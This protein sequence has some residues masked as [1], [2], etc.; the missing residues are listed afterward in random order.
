MLERDPRRNERFYKGLSAFGAPRYRK[1]LFSDECKR[2]VIN[3]HSVSKSVLR[4]MA[5]NGHVKSP[6]MRFPKDDAGIAMP[7]IQMVSEGI[8]NASTGTF[9]CQYHDAHFIDAIDRTPIQADDP[10]VQDLLLYRAVL[11]ELWLLLAT[12][13]KHSEMERDAPH[14][15]NFVPPWGHQS[16]RIESLLYLRRCLGESLGFDRSIVATT[17]VRHM[18]RKVRTDYPILACSYAFGGTAVNIEVDFAKGEVTP[19]GVPARRGGVEPHICWGFTVIPETGEHT[20]LMSWLEGSMSEDYFAHFRNLSGKELEAAV[21]AEL[22][23]FCERW[24]L[25]PK[26]WEAYN[27]E[28]QRAILIAYDNIQELMTGKFRWSDRGKQLWYEYMGVPNRHQLNLFR[29][30]PNVFKNRP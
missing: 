21:S 16:M 24:F 8:N 13:P 18:V 4:S 28:K 19:T 14:I 2:E 11:R 9:A 22:I 26:V 30:N 20:V 7:D 1:C 10:Y 27:E 23:V 15:T 3:A 29:Y 12:N 17:P 6:E 5:D 25:S